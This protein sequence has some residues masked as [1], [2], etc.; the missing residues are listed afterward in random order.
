MMDLESPIMYA[1]EKMLMRRDF[2]K[3]EPSL[4]PSIKWNLV[5]CLISESF[6]S[7]KSDPKESPLIISENT[8]HDIEMR[9][10]TCEIFFEKFQVP[11]AS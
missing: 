4:T 2:M 11:L 5:E 8:L 1:G 7:I 3:I 6:S 9:H 10:K